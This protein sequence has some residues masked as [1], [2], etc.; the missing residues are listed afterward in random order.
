MNNMITGTCTPFQKVENTRAP[1]GQLFLNVDVDECKRMCLRDSECAAVDH[2][3]KVD[4]CITHD[5]LDMAMYTR[6]EGDGCCDHFHKTNCKDHWLNIYIYIYIYI[7]IC[8][9]VCIYMC[10]WIS[11]HV[12]YYVSILYLFLLYFCTI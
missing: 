2:N 10:I 1:G 5:A 6:K 7:Y 4:L 11:V 12:L 8:L 9:Y 3:A